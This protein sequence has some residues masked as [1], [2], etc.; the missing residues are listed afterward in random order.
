MNESETRAELIDPKLKK[1]GWGIVENSRVLREFPI[2]AGRIQTGQRRAK[3]LIADYVLV[4][5]GIKL[6]VIE[7]KRADLEVGEGV[8]QAKLYAKKMQLETAYSTNGK[9]I[10]AICMKTGTEE[11]ISDFPTPEQL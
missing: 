6:A 4:Y 7:A 8:A 9:E 5:K 2:T 10:Y 11:L 3:K 1:S